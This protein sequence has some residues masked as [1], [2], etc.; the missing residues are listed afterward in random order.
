MD[1]ILRIGGFTK[2]ENVFSLMQILEV[3][4]MLNSDMPVKVLPASTYARFTMARFKYQGERINNVPV[5][6]CIA[7]E[8]SIY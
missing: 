8:N 3:P 7:L 1:V 4:F 6:Q 5:F 2:K